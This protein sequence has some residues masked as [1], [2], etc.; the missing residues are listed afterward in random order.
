[1]IGNAQFNFTGFPINTYARTTVPMQKVAIG[2]F[3]NNASV[4]AK[5]HVNQFLLA[6]NPVTDGLMFRTDGSNAVTNQWQLFTGANANSTTQK[7]RLFV[8]A[9]SVNATLETTQP[10]SSLIINT[11]GIDR[12]IIDSLGNVTINNLA[13]NDCLVMANQN[14]QLY[15]DNNLIAHLENKIA[16]LE[17]KL[18]QL[19]TFLAKNE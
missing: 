17:K 10:G 8:P 13:C 1:M 16:L 5:L 6:N 14:G 12:M 19:E 9:N 3:P 18:A 15:T 7:F 4:Q 11:T 2:N